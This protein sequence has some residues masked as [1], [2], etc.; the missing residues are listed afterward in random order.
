MF[1]NEQAK[2]KRLFSFVSALFTCLCLSMNG[3]P[4]N[5][6]KATAKTATANKSKVLYIEGTSDIF[7]NF[8]ARAFRSNIHIV[9]RLGGSIWKEQAAEIVT[10]YNNENKVFFNQPVETY[11]TELRQDYLPIP[12]EE[13][14]P[15]LKT[16]FEGRPAKKYLGYAKLGKMG[17]QC[18][19]ELTCIENNWLTPVAHRMWCKFLGLNRYDFGLPVLLT[20]RRASI[21]SCE[22][23]VVKLG[24]PVWVRV[25]VTNN[26]KEVPYTAEC[27]A[28]NPNWKQAKDKAALLFS[29]NGNLEANDLDDFF[30]S[31]TK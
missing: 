15:P 11:L 13:F 16:V 14:E 27:F 6:L 23:K 25:L 10:V 19:V 8:K 30:R 26:I 24:R 5:A 2:G 4:A 9:S 1:E 22:E 21:V 20:Q 28:V 31:D 29:Q 3:L 17:R 7:V 18:V 12:I